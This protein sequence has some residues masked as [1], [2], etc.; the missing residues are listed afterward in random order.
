MRNIPKIIRPIVYT[1]TMKKS[2]SG[3]TIV[4]LLIVIVVIGI[5]AAIVIV[6]YNGI[7]QRAKNT[8]RIAVGDQWVKLFKVYQAQF[9]S[10][11]PSLVSASNGAKFCLGT[12]FPIG[13]GGVARCQNVTGT[14]TNSPIESDN[15]TLMSELQTV[16][17][18]PT[19][20]PI[21]APVTGPYLV[22]SSA[23]SIYVGIGLDGAYASGAD[24]G[25]GYTVA[26][27]N[28]TTAAL[29]TKYIF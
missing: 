3:F 9:D 10:M 5:L 4:E 27:T 1:V 8:S 29:C 13:G 23:T 15:A 11:P 20:A 14:D 7:N 24:C 18:L 17:S 19:T 6:A 12:G 26:W 22:K 21:R 2:T 25:G 16:G 28:T